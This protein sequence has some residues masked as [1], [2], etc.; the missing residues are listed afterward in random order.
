MKRALTICLFLT[1]A[2]SGLV[3][4]KAQEMPEMPKPQKEH[5]FLHKFVGEWESVGKVK[6]A[7]DQPE[8][9][10]NGTFKARMLGGFWVISEG[11][12]E[13]MGPEPTE[14]IMTLGFDTKKGK[15][16]GTWADSMMNH[17]WKYE[18]TVEG[19][20]LT[21]DTEGPDMTDPSGRMTKYQDVFEFK[22]TDHYTLTS[23]AQGKDGQWKT[24]MTAEVTR[25]K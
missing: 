15:Y 12:G 1:I 20:K 10:C 22:S 7:E 17:M 23:R 4:S 21:L 13:G 6:M 2:C 19:D 14:S 8:M 18:G 25:K 24:F 16:V 5:E 11:K 9:E 3:K